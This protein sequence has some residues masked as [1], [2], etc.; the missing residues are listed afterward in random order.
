MTLTGAE[1]AEE[2]DGRSKLVFSV[3]R[4]LSGFSGSVI[5]GVTAGCGVSGGIVRLCYIN[6][7]TLLMCQ[8]KK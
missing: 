3:F 7:L 1:F 4:V 6:S 8:P 5:P 2:A